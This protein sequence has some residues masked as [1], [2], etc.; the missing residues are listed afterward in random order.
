MDLYFLSVEDVLRLHEKSIERFGGTHGI[1]DQSGLESAV[2]H[3]KNLFYYRAGDIFDIASAYAF[4]IAE[5]QSFL[6]GNKRTA[7]ICCLSFLK[8][9]GVFGDFSEITIYDLVI[10]IAVKRATKQD[11]AG[12]L[13]RVAA[14]AGQ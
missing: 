5:G 2:H 10:G 7:V 8:G 13:R 14:G 9:N 6:D 12:Y 4:H 1:R 11:L 3:P